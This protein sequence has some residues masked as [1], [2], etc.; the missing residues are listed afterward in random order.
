M[1]V[2][3]LFGDDSPFVAV[4]DMLLDCSLLHSS[5]VQWLFSGSLKIMYDYDCL[6]FI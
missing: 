4:D 6:S 5:T 1:P 2:T 3:L